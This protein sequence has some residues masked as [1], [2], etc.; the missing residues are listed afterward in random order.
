MAVHLQTQV[1]IATL[2]MLY[3]ARGAALLRSNGTTFP[4]L[5]GNDL[6]GNTGF[7][8]IGS[9][10]LLGL[11][12]PIW[13][14]VIF[15]LIAT[16][17]ATKTPFGRQ[18][19]AVGG[20]E[21]AAELSGVRTNWIKV[22]VYMISGFCAAVVGFDSSPDVIQSIKQGAIKATV[23]QPAALLATTAVDQASVYIQTKVAPKEEKQSIPCELVTPDNAGDYG[24]FARL[25]K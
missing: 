8:L 16:F 10:T 9:G 20:N 17:I 6:L 4:N 22:I 19:Y 3:L 11:P 1:E 5:V 15:A 13:I 24:V 23:L 7:P 21:R 18:V 12:Y 14:M 2:G 25:T